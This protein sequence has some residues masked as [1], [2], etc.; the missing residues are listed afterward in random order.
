MMDRFSGQGGIEAALGH[1]FRRPSLLEQALT[2]KSFLNERASA[3]VGHNERLEFLGDAVLSLVMTDHLIERFPALS[4][5]ALS[6]IKARLV[7]EVCLAEAAKR[8]G[9]GEF[10]RLGRGEELTQGRDKPSL[11]AD[12]L[13]A[14]TAAIYLDE[15]LEAA[16]SFVLRV[17]GQALAALERQGPSP[18]GTDYK[19]QLQ[20]YCQR[21]FEQLPLYRTTGESGPDHRKEFAVEV[22]LRGAVWGTG[23]GLTKKKAEQDAARQA[24]R[25]LEDEAVAGL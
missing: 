14:V 10:L 19:T 13:E 7:S 9:L 3:I 22:L 15:G 12:A 24:L 4:E 5:G 2:H 21:R 8:L 23:H 20:E 11:L 1:A 16:R 18:D 25:R 17:L 6:K